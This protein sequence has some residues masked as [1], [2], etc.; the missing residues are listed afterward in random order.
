MAII[1]GKGGS[2]SPK[3]A[4]VFRNPEKIEFLEINFLGYFDDQAD[5][6]LN[7]QWRFRTSLCKL[8]N[9]ESKTWSKHPWKSWNPQ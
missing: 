9:L 6:N 4:D 2:Q 7:T 3:L 5:C 8:R 1:I